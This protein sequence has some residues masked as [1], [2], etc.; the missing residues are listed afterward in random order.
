MSVGKWIT[1]VLMVTLYC[2]CTSTN[3]EDS[4][5]DDIESAAVEIDFQTAQIR[6]PELGRFLANVQADLLMLRDNSELE[7]ADA[8]RSALTESFGP[9]QAKSEDNGWLVVGNAFRFLPG[10]CDNLET[11]ETIDGRPTFVESGSL[12]LFYEY[13]I[14]DFATGSLFQSY[15]Q[16]SAGCETASV[17]FYGPLMPPETLQIV[18]T[19]GRDEVES[20]QALVREGF[21]ERQ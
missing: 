13:L 18:G 2:G 20:L 7:E 21:E 11:V 6:A 14:G 4:T 5:T 17:E 19:F 1:R 16:I 9:L 12:L 8:T 10:L 3:V 15:G